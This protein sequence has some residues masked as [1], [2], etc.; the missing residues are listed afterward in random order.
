VKAG[1]YDYLR[2]GRLA[3]LP[4]QS[5]TR[6]P[7]QRLRGHGYQAKQVLGQPA[8]ARQA[9]IA[10]AGEEDAMRA[11]EPRIGNGKIEGATQQRLVLM[12]PT[13]HQGQRSCAPH[14]RA[15][16]M[17]APDRSPTVVRIP[18]HRGAGYL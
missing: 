5:S 6:L 18:L 1:A 17:T 11:V 4:W 8:S 14:R 13:S 3:H 16:Y 10:C 7:G 9:R 15:K 12:D 2:K